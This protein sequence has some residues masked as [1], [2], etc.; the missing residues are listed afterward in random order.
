MSFSAV[1]SNGLQALQDVGGVSVT[2]QR[3]SDTVS[4]TALIGDTRVELADNY[5]GVTVTSPIRD[6]IIRVSDLVLGGSVIE[7]AAGD[8]IRETSGSTTYV[9]EVMPAGAD[10]AFRYS[11]RYRTAWRIHT[12]HVDTV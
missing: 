12:K 2:Y 4:V 8:Q 7:P 10:T 3:G 1:Y 5:G 9:F 6:Y 11:D